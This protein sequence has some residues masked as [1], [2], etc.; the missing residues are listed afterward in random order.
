MPHGQNTVHVTYRL[1]EG[2][3][4]VRFTLRPSVHFRGYEAPVD[5]VAGAG[6]HHLGDAATA[7]SCRRGTDAADAAACCCTAT[8]AALTLDE[9]GDAERAVPDGG[10]AR[11]R[12][13]GLAVESRAT[14]APTLQAGRAGHAHRL[15]RA[16]GHGRRRCR[17]TAPRRPRASGAGGC[18]RSPTARRATPFAAELVLA[19]DQF[20][21]TPAGRVE[22]AARARA[23][24][25]RSAHGDRRLSLVHRLGPR[26]DD[27]PRGA[28]AVDAPLP[29]GGLHPAH[30][31]ALRARRTDPEHVPRRR[32]AKG[33]ITPPTRRCGSSTRSSVTSASTGDDETLRK[34]LPRADR[35]R[36]AP[37]RAARASAS[38]SIRADGL[39]HAGGRRATSSRGWTR[40]STT[41]SSRRAA[42]R[43]WRST[44]SGTTRCA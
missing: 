9:K 4:P 36:P 14:S 27:Q 17:P 24:R 2:G 37:P 5:D 15:G 6:L 30:L 33:C 11:L 13:D 7:T 21:I 1:L 31:R 3:G 12:V 18:S 39:L 41:G 43:P 34:L 22:E 16:V 19:A 10:A 20:I 44:R 32:S 40:R 26:H 29:R 28:D 35:H 23:A 25:R 38:A 42:A 8:R